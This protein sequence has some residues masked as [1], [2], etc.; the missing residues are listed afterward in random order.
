MRSNRFLTNCTWYYYMNLCS[1][2]HLYIS[3]THYFM[4]RRNYKLEYYIDIHPKNEICTSAATDSYFLYYFD[5]YYSKSV[6]LVIE[7]Y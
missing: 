2:T 1:D 7:S 4:N 5:N 6:I 3:I